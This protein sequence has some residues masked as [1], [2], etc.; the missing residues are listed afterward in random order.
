MIYLVVAYVV[1]VLILGGF[2]WLSVGTL[3]K[4]SVRASAKK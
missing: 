3:R 1:A 2:L 4:L